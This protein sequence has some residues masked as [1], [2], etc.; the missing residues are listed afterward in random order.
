MKLKI[1]ITLI[2]M[3][4]IVFGCFPNTKDE[5]GQTTRKCVPTKKLDSN[6]DLFTH[7]NYTCEQIKRMFEVDFFPIILLKAK[8]NYTYEEEG[9]GFNHIIK[10]EYYESYDF[11]QA[12]V[13]NCT[14]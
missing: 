14:N 4:F 2:M 10:T 6:Y 13:F 8:I 12:Y 5:P 3:A 11:K 1:I 7:H 9:C